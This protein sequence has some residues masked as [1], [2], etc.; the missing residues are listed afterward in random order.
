M[1]LIEYGIC[2]NLPNLIYMIRLQLTPWLPKDLIVRQPTERMK[3][4]RLPNCTYYLVFLPFFLFK[5]K[6]NITAGSERTP[7]V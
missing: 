4:K 6:K 5:Y 2:N 3:K 1:Q 7:C